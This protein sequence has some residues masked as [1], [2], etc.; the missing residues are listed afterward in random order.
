MWNVSYDV[1][2]QTSIGVRYGT[3]SVTVDNSKING[4]LDILKKANPFH[5]NINEKGACQIKG[6]LTT[7]MRTIPYDA[8]GRITKETLVL[9]LNGERENFEI[10]GTASAPFPAEEKEQTT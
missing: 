5:G 4:I 1:I 6:E 3:M 9:R 10:T 7:L 2:M 8:V